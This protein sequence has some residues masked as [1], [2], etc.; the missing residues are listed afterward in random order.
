MKSIPD[1]S[2]ETEHGG[3]VAGI[4]EAGRGPLCGPVVAAAVV[5]DSRAGVGCVSMKHIRGR[6]PRSCPASPDGDFY[7]KSPHQ[8]M[9]L[10][11]DSKQMTAKQREAAFDWIMKNCE[12]GIGECSPDE[13]DEINILQASLLAMK[14][15]VD[16]LPRR[17]D[18]CLVDGNKM[19]AGLTGRAVVRGDAKSASIAAASV[20]A[21]VSR[22]RIMTRLAAD[23]PDYGW[24]KNAGYPT[25]FH[26]AALAA[27]GPTPHHRRSFRLK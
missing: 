2:L 21:K 16:A 27:H 25:R 14:R 8:A 7:K 12:V 15:A 24:D 13:I 19:P 3:I 6:S 10:I 26:Y 9:P 20:V 1:F 22:D 5:F 4:D 11:T 23:F 18:F 17:P